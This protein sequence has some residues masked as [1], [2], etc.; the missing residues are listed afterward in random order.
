MCFDMGLAFI[1]G[2]A[3]MT[4]MRSPFVFDCLE[5][6]LLRFFL[7]ETF[8][9]ASGVTHAVGSPALMADSR[10]DFIS[11]LC[12]SVSQRFPS[13]EALKCSFLTRIPVV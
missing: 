9:L 7:V 1:A 4:L 6:C 13:P 11:L 3:C 10:R 12:P 2:S 8:L 5:L